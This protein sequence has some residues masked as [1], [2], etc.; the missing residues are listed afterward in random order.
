MAGDHAGRRRT[1]ERDT[2]NAAIIGT[3]LTIDAAHTL[4]L[5]RTNE[6]G[7]SNKC[8]QGQNENQ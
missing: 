6:K 2:N 7:M 3:S 4:E 5:R 1:H 8:R